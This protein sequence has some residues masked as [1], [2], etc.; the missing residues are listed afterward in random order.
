MLISE[1]YTKGEGTGLVN[2]NGAG[3]IVK[4]QQD[5]GSFY[6]NFALALLQSKVCIGWHWFKYMDE[7]PD[8]TGDP[9]ISSANKGTVDF[10]FNPYVPLLTSMHDLNQHVYGL[11]SYFDR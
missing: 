8:S 10:N 2:Q 1:F 7:D 5:R 3:W 11:A 9:S 4:T 6:Q